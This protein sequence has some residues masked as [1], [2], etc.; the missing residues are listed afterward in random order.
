MHANDRYADPETATIHSIPSPN[1]ALIATLQ[2][3]R[4]LV[5]CATSTGILQAWPVPQDFT[6]RCTYIRWSRPQHTSSTEANLSTIGTSTRVSLAD[7]ETIRIYD[8]A[9][10]TWQATIT[11]ASSNLGK[12]ANIA[13]GSDANE[14]LVF[15]DFGVK[16]TIWSL[17]TS[18]G[19]EIRD[20]KYM[21]ACFDY[22]P[23]SGH[24]ALITRRYAQDVLLL[25]EPGSYEVLKSV[26]LGTIDAQE[27]CW[28][29]DGCWIALRDAA[30][31]GH[32]VQ[33]YT[34][35][36]QLYRTFTGP[37]YDGQIEIGVKCLKWSPA[38]TLL[39][40]DYNGTVTVLSKNIVSS[41]FQRLRQTQVN[42]LESFRR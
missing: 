40:G 24:F 35:D 18:R 36:G 23:T 28:S 3:S 15:S 1:G 31:A 13:F 10:S 6:S 26:E 14:I 16:L 37:E 11:G 38:G 21:T 8:L 41:N 7:A 30:S 2:R 34:A 29:R 25:M 39:V 42:R 4:L 27:V 22:R 5:R 12:P 17:L 33:I 20:P 32:R 19:V 9:D